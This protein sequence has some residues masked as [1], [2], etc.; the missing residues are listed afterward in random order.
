MSWEP[1]RIVQIHS[2]DR[3]LADEQNSLAFFISY[4]LNEV[5]LT[6]NNVDKLEHGY[7][8][9]QSP[10]ISPPRHVHRYARVD[11][12]AGSHATMSLSLPELTVAR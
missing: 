9:S 5:R 2:I 1:L 12:K 3:P 11:R 8:P 6:A 7:F 4:R 10:L